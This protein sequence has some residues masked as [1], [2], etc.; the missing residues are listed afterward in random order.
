[1]DA[2]RKENNFSLW[3]GGASGH[4][5]LAWLWL[6]C[7][8]LIDSVTKHAARSWLKRERPDAPALSKHTELEVYPGGKMVALFYFGQ[9]NAKSPQL[10]LAGQ[11]AWRSR[12]PIQSSCEVPSLILILQGLLTRN[13]FGQPSLQREDVSECSGPDSVK[14]SAA[15]LS[16]LRLIA[17]LFFSLQFF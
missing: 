3:L 12:L 11:A 7:L 16:H 5:V 8:Q 4:E 13:H 2:N 17:P 15:R 6:V 14:S 10:D 9:C 1:M